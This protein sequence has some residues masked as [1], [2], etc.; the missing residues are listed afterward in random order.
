LLG[1]LLF[2]AFL[3]S[4]LL[5]EKE[6]G[7][8]GGGEAAHHALGGGGYFSFLLSQWPSVEERERE[9]ER[10]EREREGGRERE[11]DREK[12][13]ERERD[14]EHVVQHMSNVRKQARI[15]RSSEFPS[16]GHV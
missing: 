13:R 12:E 10:E 4:S 16:N 2:V 7:E 5:T 14:R 11:I 6:K 3:P 8:R 9:R 1:A 15:F